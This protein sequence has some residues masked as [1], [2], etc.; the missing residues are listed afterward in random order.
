MNILCEEIDFNRKLDFS[1]DDDIESPKIKNKKHFQKNDIIIHNDFRNEDSDKIL[2]KTPKIPKVITKDWLVDRFAKLSNCGGKTIDYRKKYTFKHDYSYYINYIYNAHDINNFEADIEFCESDEQ[3]EMWLFMRLKVS[4]FEHTSNTVGR[5]IKILIRDK[6]TWKYVGVASL[7]SDIPCKIYDDEIGWNDKIKFGQKMFNHVMNITT[8][9]GIPP[10]CYNFNGG[11]LVAM[12]MF[13]K[14]VYD[15][16]Y[17]KYNDELAC[18]T[19]FSLYGKSIQYDRITEY[20][21]FVGLT[22]GES[23]INLPG[24]FHSALDTFAVQNEM[25]KKFRSRLEKISYMI[26]KFEFPNEFKRGLQKGCYIGFTGTNSK[27]FL[28]KKDT[29]FNVKPLKNVNEISEEWKSR[30]ANNRY[31]NLLSTKKIMLEC[32]YD[33]SVVDDKD[34]ERIKKLKTKKETT[35]KKKLTYDE[36][37]EILSYYNEHKQPMTKLEQHFS[38]KFDK[39]VNRS[40][41]TLLINGN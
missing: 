6:K 27:E 14:E 26:R 40:T 3:K 7:G 37:I 35:N 23:T 8:C 13:S 39:K 19:T 30:W 5:C 15:Y 36:K 17:K 21:N 29:K 9:I 4:S 22:K 31:T 18:I 16:V 34:Y 12:L 20:L 10:F 11:K 2:R 32:N 25:T 41:I 33:T 1:S 28:T 38:E 24:W